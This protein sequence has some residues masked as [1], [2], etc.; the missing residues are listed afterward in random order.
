MH[1]TMH[2]VNPAPREMHINLSS[3]MR[4]YHG[5]QQKGLLPLIVAEATHIDTILTIGRVLTMEEQHYDDRR[6]NRQSP[7]AKP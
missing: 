1:V 2:K 4:R 7:S 6:V 5:R 3:I